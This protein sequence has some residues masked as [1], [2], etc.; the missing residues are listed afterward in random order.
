MLTSISYAQPMDKQ[1]KKATKSATVATR[2]QILKEKVAVSGTFQAK[3]KVQQQVPENAIMLK[4]FPNRTR[5]LLDNFLESP[6][7]RSLNL[8]KIQSTGKRNLPGMF[9]Y[10]ETVQSVPYSI[11]FDT[12]TQ[13]AFNEFM[14][15]DNNGDGRTWQ[16]NSYY[17]A[18][19]IYSSSN[20]ADEYFIAPPISMEASK[21]YTITVNVQAASTT[22]PE[23]F[24][25]L[26]GTE[27]TVAGLTTTALAPVE[28]NSTTAEDYEGS[29]TPAASG[30]YYVAIHCISDANMWYL[31]LNQ[32]SVTIGA[33]QDAPA[34]PTV[35]ATPGENGALTATVEVTAP[36]NAINGEKLQG[37]L[38]KVEIYRDGE[39]V[40][41]KEDVA[42]GGK[43][44]YT[45]EELTNGTHK[46][47]A[48]AYN[49]EGAGQ[50]SEETSVYVGVDEPAAPTNFASEDQVSS[51]LFSWDKVTSGANGGYFVPEDV[52]YNIYTV[53][54]YYG[55]LYLNE[56]IATVHNADSYTYETNTDEGEQEYAYWGL[57]ASNAGGENGRYVTSMLIGKPYDLPV[58]EGFASNSMHYVWDYNGDL[59]YLSYSTDGDGYSKALTL[60][61]EGYVY[62][63]SGK[64]NLKDASNPTLLI[65]VAG[66]ASTVY[67]IGFADDGE[68][69]FIDSYTPNDSNFE[70]V[71]VPLPSEIVGERFSQIGFLIQVETPYDGTSEDYDIVYFDNIRI[72]DI[73]SNDLAI[74]VDAPATV[75]AGG[76][77]TITAYVDNLG[78]NDAS[79]YNVT[80]KVG[81]NVLLNET[82][83]E[84]LAAGDSKEFTAEVSGI[85]YTEFACETVE[86][87][88]A[89]DV[90]QVTDN[91][92]DENII[93]FD[94]NNELYIEDFEDTET[95]PT[96]S[97]GGITETEHNG[98]FG[99]WTLYDP[100]GMI[101]YY[102]GN[103]A[104]D[105]ENKGEACAWQVFDPVQAGFESDL[106]TP[107]SG[108][109]FLM[110]MSV[111]EYDDADNTYPTDHWLISPELI[112]TAQT[113][114]F[115]YRIIT[116]QYG[117]ETFEVLASST[118]NKPESFTKIQDYTTVATDWTKGYVVLPEGTKYFAVRHTS[119]DIFGLY[120]DDFYFLKAAAGWQL[121][122][123]NHDG[124]VN[125]TDVML[126]V[127]Y[128]LGQDYDNFYRDEADANGDGDV[129]ITDIATIVD[130]VLKTNGSNN[131]EIVQ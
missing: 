62:F 131:P 123:V 13:D 108:S 78:E 28:I 49:A 58:T 66:T 119:T 128:L 25:I 51:I 52:D 31:R 117:P 73:P 59:Y 109:Q 88:V 90:D 124:Q 114:S 80:I 41:T 34:A 21:N 44:T 6:A 86:A 12:E 106:N 37:N 94:P 50:K 113:I 96:F 77:A 61:E 101:V 47:Y 70:T 4:P 72:V 83:N 120:V 55:Y 95:F 121:G 11:T 43:F 5:T 110:S 98:S 63:L 112:G 105:Y 57:T 103:D 67:F 53:T 3:E 71:T 79:N 68:M 40:F 54:N 69:Q 14:V 17:G 29:F 32:F 92:V 99:D 89:Y 64:V 81:N 39:L 102:W 85:D 60:D 46:Y 116:D 30:T 127:S 76:K 48:I 26:V 65:D 24:E 122:D 100:T 20:A 115:Y 1:M 118:D 45:D 75:N 23:R 111:S 18:H 125:V 35:T 42:P 22:Y 84:A 97:V 130:M 19:C 129:N 9:R 8:G 38:T 74:E 10:N 36:K 15:I 27:A 104:I 91:N 82:V 7:A 87:K 56:K 126:T 93:Y 2:G 33:S 16:W 107:H